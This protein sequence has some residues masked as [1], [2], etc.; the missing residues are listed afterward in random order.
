MT[1][2][3]DKRLR[4]TDANGSHIGLTNAQRV[5]M[6]LREMERSFASIAPWL[7]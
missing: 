1:L 6:W 5:V 4:F 3:D 2:L 7:P